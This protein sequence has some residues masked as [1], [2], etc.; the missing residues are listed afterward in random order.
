M[1]M[2]C[3]NVVRDYD[4]AQSVQQ[5]DSRLQIYQGVEPMLSSFGR[6]DEGY[7]EKC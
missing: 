4:D 5:E 6:M 7:E 2:K 1:G 3:V